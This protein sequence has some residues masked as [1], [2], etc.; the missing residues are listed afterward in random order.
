MEPEKKGMTP[1]EMQVR[2]QEKVKQ[3][4]DLMSVLQISCEAR[5]HVSREGFITKVVY[6]IDEEKYPAAEPE[7][8]KTQNEPA[9]KDS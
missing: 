4:T 3:I 6:W 1:A 7:V 2:S 9:P 5:E 8:T